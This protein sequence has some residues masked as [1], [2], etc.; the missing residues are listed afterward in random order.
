MPKAGDHAMQGGRSKTLES[1]NP[2]RGASRASGVK[3]V[4]DHAL[5]VGSNP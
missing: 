5:I 3:A 2:K 4:P 1:G